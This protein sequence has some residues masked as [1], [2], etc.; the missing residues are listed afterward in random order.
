MMGRY[1]KL[2]LCVSLPERYTLDIVDSNQERGDAL[3]RRPVSCERSL[4]Q[5]LKQRTPRAIA[6]GIHA[7]HLPAIHARRQQAAFD[8][9]YA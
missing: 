7:L 3:T 5:E 2:A 4:N 9:A 1:N 6:I 8:V